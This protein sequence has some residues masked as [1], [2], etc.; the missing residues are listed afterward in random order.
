VRE[1]SPHSISVSKET[2]NENNSQSQIVV[3]SSEKNIGHTPT[4]TG[5]LTAH[6]KRKFPSSPVTSGFP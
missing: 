2:S 6:R 4:T 3:P 1:E 5:R